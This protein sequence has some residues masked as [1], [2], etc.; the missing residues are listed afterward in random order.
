MQIGGEMYSN[1]AEMLWD[2]PV[3]PCFL[4]ES[5]WCL[6]GFV[7]LAFMS[8]RRKYDGQLALMYMAW[9]GAERFLVEGLRTDSLMVGN[10]RISQALSAVIFITSV[11]IQIITFFRL[12]RDPEHFVLYANTEEAQ[13]LLE[14][15]RR[16][17]MGITGSDAHLGDDDEIGDLSEDDEIGILPIEDDDDD[18]IGQ[19]PD[20]DEEDI[21]EFDD[22]EPVEE[23]TSADDN[24]DAEEEASEDADAE[25]ADTEPAEENV[26][27]DDNADTEEEASEDAAAEAADAERAEENTSADDN[28]DTEEESSEDADA[29]A[30]DAEQA[31]ENISADDDAEEETA[32]QEIAE[33]DDEDSDSLIPEDETDK[34]EELAEELDSRLNGGSDKG[35]HNKNKKHMKN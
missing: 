30:D 3:H 6:L 21:E 8:K 33:P 27:A 24:A 26:S 13:L 5:V 15:S 31:E 25:T 28:A 29:E 22:A 20:E 4:Y 32:E 23:D 35:S 7:F 14:E 19:L 17:R 9:Y 10:I 18:E 12:R 11:I 2:K 34:Y 16:K 1:G